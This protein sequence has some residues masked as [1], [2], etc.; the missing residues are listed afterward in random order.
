[1]PGVE[2]L[3][4]LGRP[5][6]TGE[7]KARD[8]DR[9]AGEK[10]C[11][12]EGPEPGNEEHHLRGNEKDHAVA[13]VKLND[14]RVVDAGFLDDVAPPSHHRVGDTKEARDDPK[15]AHAMHVADTAE[16]HQKGGGRADRRP[17]ARVDK[18]IVVM[19]GVSLSHFHAPR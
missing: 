8:L 16:R 3:D 13:E 12:E 7:G 11:V 15:Q 10:A 17:R 2:N 18:V 4:A 19:L 14:G 9:L 5:M 6:T 1:V